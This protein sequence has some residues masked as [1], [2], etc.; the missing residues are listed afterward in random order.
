L[1]RDSE[2]VVCLSRSND[3]AEGK[4]PMNEEHHF[5]Q[6]TT[7]E[8]VKHY[9]YGEVG[10]ILKR[11]SFG[12]NLFTSVQLLSD[13]RLE[14]QVAVDERRRQEILDMQQ[15]NSNFQGSLTPD[16]KEVSIV[17]NAYLL[18]EEAEACAIQLIEAEISRLRK[19]LEKF[20]KTQ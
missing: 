8:D 3:A 20:R 16:G 9:R 13:G 15:M 19:K 10:D 17:T 1:R 14:V 7:V 18:R 2:R 11:T 6:V 12:G 5:Y 4:V